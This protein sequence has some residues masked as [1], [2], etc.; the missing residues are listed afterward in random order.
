MGISNSPGNPVS[1]RSPHRSKGRFLGSDL[2]GEGCVSIRSL[3]EARGD[4]I[5]V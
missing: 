2:E 3:T 1:I 4:Y 5:D